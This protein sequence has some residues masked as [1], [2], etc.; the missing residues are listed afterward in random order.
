MFSY[1]VRTQSISAEQ[2][3]S[4]DQLAG[5]TVSEVQIDKNVNSVSEYERIK[6]SLSMGKKQMS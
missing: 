3:K 1:L 4:T 6:R 2:L 5:V